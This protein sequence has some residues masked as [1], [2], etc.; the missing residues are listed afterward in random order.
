MTVGSLN[1][2]SPAVGAQAS[3]ES[4]EHRRLLDRLRQLATIGSSPTEQGGG[5]VRPAYSAAH[6]EAAEHVAAWMREAGLEVGRDVAGTIIGVLPGEDRSLPALA[7]G[8][9]LDTVPHG[10]AFDGA[11]G[12]LAAIDAAQRISASGERLPRDV[13]ILGFADEEGNNFGIGVLSAQVWIGEIEED[14]FTS[15]RDAQGKSLADHLEG[16]DLPGIPRIERPPLAG[17]LELHV[18]QGP[19]LD[20][21]N[22]TAAAVEAIVGIS[23]TTVTFRGQANHAGT[24][25]MAMRQDPL[26]AGAELVLKVRE[27]AVSSKERLVGTIGVLRVEPGATNVIPG[28]VTL[29]IELRSPDADRLAHTRSTIEATANEL[30][31]A[32][33]VSVDV[34]AWHLAPP[35]PMDG[36]MLE[37]TQEALEDISLP[38]RTMPS[39][40][41]HDAK[42]LARR[43]PVGM[44]FL[45]SVG[46]VSHAPEEWT[47]PRHVDVAGQL[48][49][50]AIRRAV[51]KLDEG[52]E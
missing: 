32:Y 50:A 42:V 13:A 3:G 16:F 33:D 34:D 47:E 9:H 44:L 14:R 23:R 43:L 20:A 45:P 1:P 21:A 27:L 26:P 7:V 8:S 35:V 30:A 37:A 48:L 12:V 29:R 6:A 36:R 19:V 40:A 4:G 28:E 38:V 39:W 2:S 15:I 17:Y 31:N 25:P 51:T 11:L 52:R 22:A 41:G 18:E 24:T 49:E 10:G 5:I 46:G